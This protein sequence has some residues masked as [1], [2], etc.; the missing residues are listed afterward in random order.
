MKA[1]YH[2][3]LSKEIIVFFIAS[4]ILFGSISG[5]AQKEHMPQ[6]SNTNTSLPSFFPMTFIY[7]TI[8]N[9]SS[10]GSVLHAN[11]TYVRCIQFQPLQTFTITNQTLVMIKPR[12]GKITSSNVFGF[13]RIHSSPI[14]FKYTKDLANDV[15]NLNGR[16]VTFNR[17]INVNNLDIS[18]IIYMRDHKQICLAVQTVNRIVNRGNIEDLYFVEDS[19]ID[20]V[21][22]TA[23]LI[24]DQRDYTID[25]V[26]RKTSLRYF[27]DLANEITINGT[28][29]PIQKNLLLFSFELVNESETYEISGCLSLFIHIN[30]RIPIA[31]LFTVLFDE[32]TDQPLS[33]V[34]FGYT[35]GVRM[36]PIDFSSQASGGIPPY[37]FLWN[38][39]DNTTATEHNPSHTYTTAGNYTV[40]VTVTDNA[41]MTAMDSVNITILPRKPQSYPKQES[42]I[43]PDFSRFFP[44]GSPWLL[45]VNDAMGAGT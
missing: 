18:S 13:M 23:L 5:F 29:H 25:Y 15:I 2:N 20:V 26:N 31:L 1:S 22:Y 24:T 41:S 8:T 16:T 38:F 12:W 21:D 4:L 42:L 28:N 9:L 35:N 37:T 44:L 19:K 17:H 33:F 14:E 40:S 34:I 45:K 3:I 43:P 7:G 36:Q 39:G 11:A 10:Y 27:N 30:L 6:P 32:L